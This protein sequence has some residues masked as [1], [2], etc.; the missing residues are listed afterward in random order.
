MNSAILRNLKNPFYSMIALG[1][2]VLF[3][4]LSYYFMANLPGTR[5]N[6][7]VI[8]AGLTTLNIAFSVALSILTGIMVA[9]VFALYRKRKSSLIATS[10]LSGVGLIV[11]S[12]TVFCA[13]CTIPVFTLFG[14]S[15]SLGF[16]TTY[17]LPIKI[18]SM[19]LMLV[20]LYLI[21]NQLNDTCEIC[22]N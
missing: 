14:L 6:M 16:F 9:S 19:L 12:F 22:R 2:S 21:N 4:D 5:N 10:S 11:G 18:V 20:S 1:S 17:D 13:A 3:F 8:G 15:L 7:C